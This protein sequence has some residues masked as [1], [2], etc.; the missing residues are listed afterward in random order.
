MHGTHTSAPNTS[1]HVTMLTADLPALL[2]D[3]AA[4][5]ASYD[6]HNLLQAAL[7]PVSFHEPSPER[8][9]HEYERFAASAGDVAK[10]SVSAKLEQGAYKSAYDLFHDIKLA[11]GIEIRNHKVGSA[12]YKEIDTFYHR[13]VAQLLREM[14]GSGVR[15]FAEKE[16]DRDELLDVDRSDYTRISTD[17][18]AAN[19]DFITYINK[20]TEPSVP[21]FHSAYNSLPPPPKTVVQ[22]LFSGLV[23]RSVLDTRNTV[24]PD[25]WGLAQALPAAPNVA[26]SN[27]Y[28]TF[29][30]TI[31]KI[32]PPSQA[33]TQVLDGFFHSNW[34]T[35][36][37]P[38]WL[39]YKQKTL[40]P[41]LDSTLVKNCD[42]NELRSFEKKSTL[43]SIGPTTDLKNA[44]LGEHVRLAV[45]FSNI[46]R[47]KIDQITHGALAP[48]TTEE[49]K[50]EPTPAPKEESEATDEAEEKP[51][52]ENGP[53]STIKLE[54]VAAFNPEELAFLDQLKQEK[55]EIVE[56]P[57]NIQK[58]ISLNLIRLNKLRQERYL[59]STTPGIATSAETILYK[60]IM[61]YMTTL[62]LSQAV[63]GKEVELGLSKKIP[64]LT[65]DYPGSLPG[66]VPA[67]PFSAGKTTRLAGMKNAYRRKGR[68]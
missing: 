26:D 37:A 44:V 55:E 62:A 27:S 14:A 47:Q 45:W 42:S 31:S 48:E 40:K 12:A 18:L 1:P 11:C 16:T 5:F 58:I 65:N 4:V 21:S 23:G 29:N 46:G 33:N 2:H 54:N 20:F 50:K 8:I 25:P 61:R 57:A 24:V 38:Q 10:T 51:A 68:F 28:R 67:K 64:V 60:K 49:V 66:P 36:E 53:Y 13:A 15:L 7:L 22:P 17:Y 41:P 30:N 32:P 43:L 56:T 34:Y 59:H 9:I 52:V 19:D 39:Q 6:T 35:I 63:A 3:L